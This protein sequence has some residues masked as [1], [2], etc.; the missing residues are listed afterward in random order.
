M[1]ETPYGVVAVLLLVITYVEVRLWWHRRR[2]GG[3]RHGADLR[4]MRA[5][6]L[7]VELGRGCPP[8]SVRS[9]TTGAPPEMTVPIARSSVRPPMRAGRRRSP[10]DAWCSP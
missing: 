7:R 3:G 9:A 8:G 2:L 1:D 10:G 6:R 4:A 5:R